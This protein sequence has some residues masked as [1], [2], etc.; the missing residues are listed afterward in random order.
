MILRVNEAKDL[1]EVDRFEFYNHVKDYI[2]SP[3]DVLRVDEKHYR[4][5]A[6]M[7]CCGV[8]IGTNY[9]TT[10]IYLPSDDRRHFVA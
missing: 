4:E 3:P 10:G 7:N 9:K 5:H 1:G 2:A 8:I 6:I